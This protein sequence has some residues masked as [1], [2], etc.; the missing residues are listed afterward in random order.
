ME[1]TDN[2]PP[3]GGV[4]Y[5]DHTSCETPLGKIFI[6]WKSWKENPDYGITIE[7]EYIDTC[8]SLENAKLK[9]LNYLLSKQEEL[10]QFLNS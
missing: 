10:Y 1:W 6:E 7:G 4:S 8:Y 5:Y 3:V 2:M 9:A